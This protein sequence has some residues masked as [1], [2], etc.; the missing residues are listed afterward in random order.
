[1]HVLITAANMHIILL[2]AEAVLFLAQRQGVTAQQNNR[3]DQ[4]LDDGRRS[5]THT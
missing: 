2:Q 5:K 4:L 3:G 1:M